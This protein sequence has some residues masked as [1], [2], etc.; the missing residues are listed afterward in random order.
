M[1]LGL[2]IVGLSEPLHL[3]DMM[4]AKIACTGPYAVKQ[5]SH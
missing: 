1:R 2:F 5:I 4:S 3:V